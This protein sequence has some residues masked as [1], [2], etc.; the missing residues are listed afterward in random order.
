MSAHNSL[1]DEIEAEIHN[2]AI[3][4]GNLKKKQ[5][6]PVYAPFIPQFEK[7]GYVARITRTTCLCCGASH[8]LLYG[9]FLREKARSGEIRDTAINLKAFA[10]NYSRPEEFIYD[11][12]SL[13]LC[14]E[15]VEVL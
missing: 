4:R 9:I 3:E 5:N 15:C 10:S 1:L 12:V 2:D 14:A 13:H 6:R 7:I 8:K 11:D